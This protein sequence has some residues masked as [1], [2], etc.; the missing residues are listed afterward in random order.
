MKGEIVERYLKYFF[1][2]LIKGEIV[3]R[4]LKYFFSNFDKR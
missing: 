4:Y 1:Q 3:E 2:T